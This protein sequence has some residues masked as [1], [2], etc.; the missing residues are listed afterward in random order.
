MAEVYTTLALGANSKNHSAVETLMKQAIRLQN[1]LL[2]T[3]LTKEMDILLFA[4]SLNRTSQ[5]YG[6]IGDLS[7]ARYYNLQAFTI[8]ESLVSSGLIEILNNPVYESIIWARMTYNLDLATL[9]NGYEWAKARSKLNGIFLIFI[10]C[11]FS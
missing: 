5:Y 4:D 11:Y 1:M 3:K 7:N 8:L 9:Q 6:T 10:D 2:Q